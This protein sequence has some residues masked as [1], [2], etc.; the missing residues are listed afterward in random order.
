MEDSPQITFST[1]QDIYYI[2]AKDV[3]KEMKHI[4]TNVNPERMVYREY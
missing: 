4:K 1:I 2:E 3:R